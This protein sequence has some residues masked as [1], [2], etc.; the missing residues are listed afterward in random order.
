[1]ENHHSYVT[2]YQRVTIL[3]MFVFSSQLVSHWPRPVGSVW[4]L[5]LVLATLLETTMTS[6]GPVNQL[7]DRKDSTYYLFNDCAACIFWVV[8]YDGI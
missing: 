4:A 2:N 5:G 1:M 3:N 7:V 6:R 8:C